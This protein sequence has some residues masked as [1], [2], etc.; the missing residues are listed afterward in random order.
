MFDDYEVQLGIPIDVPIV[1]DWIGHG[2]DGVDVFRMSNSLI[3]MKDALTTGYADRDIVYRIPNDIPVAGHWSN[4]TA[5]SVATAANLIVA[6][7]P[8]ALT[9]LPTA[10]PPTIRV[11]GQPNYDG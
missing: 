1:G 5:A 4:S 8:S 2:H 10:T 11:T 9:A 6:N 7:T 3:Y